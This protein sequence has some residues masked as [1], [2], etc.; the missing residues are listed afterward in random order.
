MLGLLV[1]MPMLAEIKEYVQEKDGNIIKYKYDTETHKAWLYDGTGVTATKLDFILQE[2]SDEENVTYQVTRIGEKAFT[3]LANNK[4]SGNINL[5]YVIIPEG[6]DKIEAN[7]FNNCS[8]IRLLELP[9]TMTTVAKNAFIGCSNMAYVCCKNTNANSAIPMGLPNNE[10]MTLFVPKDCAK[11]GEKGY[12]NPEYK[13]VEGNRFKDRIYEGEM[14]VLYSKT[15]NMTYVCAS[16]PGA[17][18]KAILIEGKRASDVEVKSNVDCEDGESYNVVGIGKS[19]FYNFLDIHTLKIGEGVTTICNNAFQ[20]C[21]NLKKLELPST[22]NTIGA[23]AFAE[24]NNLR[25]VWCKVVDAT[26]IDATRFPKSG[27]MSLYVPNTDYR[28]KGNWS[29]QFGG[30]IYLGNMVTQWDGYG[31]EYVCS[32]VSHE[33]TL[34][35]GQNE[36]KI[37]IPSKVGEGLYNVT[38][39]DRGAFSGLTKLHKVIIPNSIT[40]IGS[41]AFYG[42]NNLTIVHSKSLYPLDIDDNVF[43][44][45]AKATLFIPTSAKYD[46]TQKPGWNFYD[47]QEC[48]EMCEFSDNG[49]DYIGWT[50]YDESKYAKLIKGTSSIPEI[51]TP[52]NSY[53][54]ISIGES[55]FSGIRNLESLTISEEIETIADNAFKNCYDLKSISLP[56][57]LKSIG[58]SAFQYC[59]ALKKVTLP[60]SI[61][62]IGDNAFNGCTNL[63]EVESNMSALVPVTSTTFPNDIILYIP[64]DRTEQEYKD[65]GWIYSNCFLG[66]KVECQKSNMTY[67]YGAS[68]PADRKEAILLICSQTSETV[69]IPATVPETDKKV[70]SIAKNAF[71]NNNTMK[72]LIIPEGVESIGA[73]AFKNCSKLTT[74]VLPST[75]SSIRNYAFAQ[76]SNITKITSRIEGTKL[77]ALEENVFPSIV[78]TIYIPGGSKEYYTSKEGWKQYENSYKVGEATPN[79]YPDGIDYMAYDCYSDDHT[80][81]LTKIKSSGELIAVD[82]P[83]TIS[84]NGTTYTVTAIGESIFE[85]TS[86]NKSKIQTLVIGANVKT[87]GASAF[88]DWKGLH[89][90]SLPDG[91]VQI[92]QSAFLGDNN[93]DFKQLTIPNSV[94]TIAAYAFQG[95]TNLQNVKLPENLKSIE[96]HAFA[97]ITALETIDIPNSVDSIGAFA[98]QGCFKLN[99]KL[100]KNLKSIGDNSF[101]NISGTIS[102][103]IPEGVERIGAYAFRNCSKLNELVLPSSLLRIDPYAF[104]D[105]ANITNVISKIKEG[106]LFEIDKDV[107]PEAVR[108]AATLFVPIDEVTEG[109]GEN[110]SE[111][112]TIAKYQAT[113]GWK[114]FLL[115]NMIEGEKLQY[116][117]ESTKMVYE[118][119]TGPHKATLIGT[120]ADSGDV[121]IKS[122]FTIPTEDKPYQVIEIGESA[123]SVEKYPNTKNIITITISDGINK[124]GANAFNGCTGL[125]SINIPGTMKTIGANAFQGCTSLVKVNMDVPSVLETIESGAFMGCSVL[126]NLDLPSTLKTIGPSAFQSSGL[127]KISLRS[128]LNAIGDKAFYG[129]S[130][131]SDVGIERSTPLEISEDVF[132]LSSNNTA[133]L[134][135]PKESKS[136]YDIVG[137]NKFSNVVEGEFVD[138]CTDADLKVNFSCYRVKKD[139][140]KTELGAI[141]T[142]SIANVTDMLL[143]KELSVKVEG[144]EQQVSYTLTHI[145]KYAFNNCT[146]LKTVELPSSL[147]S[148]GD[149]AFANCSLIRE[150]VSNIKQDDLFTISDDVFHAD[151]KSQAKLYVPIGSKGTYEGKDYWS[152]FTHDNIENGK[153]EQTKTPDEYYLKYRYHTGKKKASVIEIIFPE[154]KEELTIPSSFTIGSGEDAVTYD[155]NSISPSVFNNK[156]KVRKL[157]IEDTRSEEGFEGISSIGA[158]AFQGC[159][160][161]QKIWLPKSVKSIGSKAFYGCNN[162]IRIC[163]ESMPTIENTDAFTAYSSALLFVP[164][165]TMAT[166]GA[167]WRDFSR[168]YEG[169]YEDESPDG[170]SRA[171][172]YLKQTGDKYTAILT[173]SKTPEPI[174]SPV[175]NINNNKSYDVTI[176]GKSAFTGK[177]LDLSEWTSLPESV[178]AIENDAFKNCKLKELA[179]PSSLKTIGNGAFSANNQLVKITLPANLNT[180]G[181]NAFKGCS[182]LEKIELPKNI[183]TLGAGV[184]EDCS[185]MTEV[186]SKIET[187]TVIK[188][189]AQSVPNAILYVP[190]GA[191]N[192]YSGW[193]FLYTLEGDSKLAR[194]VD[195]LDYAY[196]ASENS[197]NKAILIG[198][199]KISEDGAVTIPESVTI[200]NVEYHVV[201]VGKDVLYGNLNLKKLDIKASLASIGEN[202]FSGCSNLSEIICDKYYKQLDAL[203]QFDVLLYVLNETI[204]KSY[205]DAGWNSNHV[206]VGVRVEKEFDDG[207]KYAYTEGGS[208]A[209]LIGVWD[210][211]KAIDKNGAVIIPDY[212]EFKVDDNDNTKF[213]VISIANSVFKDNTDVRMVTIGENIASI[214]EN[215]FEGCTNLKEIVS[216]ISDTDVI[217]KILFSKPDAILFITD[218]NLFDTYKAKWDVSYILAGARKA[219]NENGLYYTCAT[220]DKVAILL[221]G[222]ASEMN[223]D[224][225]ILGSIEFKVND[226]DEEN[227]TFKVIAIA[228]N[229]FKGNT[230]MNT[231]TIGNNIKTIGA[232]A[233][234]GCIGLNKIWFPESLDS[235]AEKAFN[236]CYDIS[237]ICTKRATPQESISTNVFS[238]VSS[239]LYVPYGSIGAYSAN[240]V[241]GSFSKIKEGV[242]VDAIN[243]DGV[244]YECVINDKDE[245]VAQIVK[246]AASLTDVIIPSEVKLDQTPYRVAGIEDKAFEACTKLTVITSKISKDNLFDFNEN[247]FPESIYKSAV[248]YVPNDDETEAKY[249]TT[250]G[251]KKFEHWARGEKKTRTVGEMTYD[252]LVGVGTA[253]LTKTTLNTEKVRVD[254]TVKI[255]DVTYTVT[256]IGA[257]AFKTCNK[258][259]MVWLP[260]TLK[261]IDKLAFAGCYSIGYVSC[262]MTK[263]CDIDANTFPST[264]AALFV[265]NGYKSNYDGWKDKFAYMAEGELVDVCTDTKFSYDCVKSDGKNKAILRKYLAYDNEVEI[266]GTVNLSNVAYTVATIAKSSFENKNSITSLV[267]PAGVEEIDEGVFSGCSKLIWI[268]SKIEA[269][270]DIR[271]KNVFNNSKATLFIPSSAKVDAYTSKGWNFLNIFLGEKK[272]TTVDGWTYTYSTGDKKA[273]LTKVG[274]V[275]KDVTINGM[276]TI[277]K[278]EYTVTSVGEAV[279][280]GKT[281]IEALTIAK[282][283]ENIGANAF[284]GCNNLTFI[285]CEGTTPPTLGANAFP[286]YSV[287]VNVPNDAVGT[288]KNHPDWKPFGEHILGITTSVEDDPTG[289][290][291]ILPSTDSATPEVELWNGSDAEGDVVLTEIVTIGGSDFTL[292]AIAANAYDGNTAIT[293]I[294]IPSTVSSIGASAFAGCTNLKSITVNRVTPI[295]LST[296]AGVRGALTRAGG[297]SV[298]E[299]VNKETCIL[300]VPAESIDAYKQATGWKDFKKIY[301]IGTTA[302]NGIVISEGKPFDVYNL[303]GRKVKANTTSFSGLPS[304]V[305]IVKGKKVMVK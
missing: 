119:L 90:L 76:C 102:L 212:I 12:L 238:K 75:L 197:G 156:N 255:D 275:G 259:K 89:S 62:T 41:N 130:S 264:T 161:L 263:P 277:G 27:M 164:T 48:E 116:K 271:N 150:V 136:A 147:T 93:A 273:I 256:A 145:G 201:A 250:D 81:T 131:L 163:I 4:Y 262:D 260:S 53:N 177:V 40:T 173:N 175:T 118:Y 127:Q 30:R 168:K 66:H 172:I 88:K 189:N 247:V 125:I 54:V 101:E 269:P 254:G 20:K 203:S 68:D 210:K 146:N 71:L 154:D 44:S 103:S 249:K 110:E 34:Y 70:I 283:I 276:F 98:F 268:Q 52:V 170:V 282:S 286:S 32:T 112:K 85:G 187:E 200:E 229:A 208:E 218:A 207:L 192:R 50:K 129:C 22:L 191:A 194:D 206:Y 162:L 184:F 232:S 202:A 302:I 31:N 63:V 246:A 9:S 142:K 258:L 14:K 298:F 120:Y 158:N 6:I 2:F 91:L 205:V 217:S 122:S 227:T 79:V 270:I 234:Q 80:A 7:A 43:S 60:S 113:A 132:S 148:I 107:F 117:D 29:A 51:G 86:E 126:R 61:T 23:G 228:E 21:A 138:A 272:E 155:V 297:S 140:N 199:T 166:L 114:E 24:C 301:A 185:G 15:E 178:V 236:G 94:T 17:D 281:N 240:S 226:N 237:Y 252:Y 25:H 135:V 47:V 123:F 289:A 195:G 134:F 169:Y 28:S 82:V 8:N 293:S 69:D 292:T 176:I 105:C 57:T 133:T 241:W 13:W 1:S 304:G 109:E 99:I 171:Y 214:G 295:D 141:I 19:A 38:G 181:D 224:V 300:Y 167:G 242:F 290:Y 111:S 95:C 18:H 174:Q 294:V 33:A 37:E 64:S 303:Q 215:A 104:A 58:K 26:L 46:Y 11:T 186:I 108:N 96:N 73:Y 211:D 196:T 39:V 296:V 278:D 160:N 305:Y 143:K 153:W 45:K 67:V 121:T 193:D 265:P 222:K 220:G 266:P 221:E 10:L 179:L 257:N 287:T 115:Q 288:Y 251:W 139:E 284:D 144:S 35:I 180:L 233:F 36:T 223:K 299:G 16:G 274:N 128:G 244:T 92:G 59:I 152:S 188:S 74:I 209:I 3:T 245:N 149:K 190:D 78:P 235:I 77:F 204:K 5:D 97:N 84:V 239:T 280:K 65:C 291:N 230:D 183:T 253:T 243:Q 219:W 267:I 225:D 182:S 87:I 42:C 56:S 216:K 261:E 285:T 100:P 137:W 49:I 83:A 279:F 151:V 248:V 55:A 231:L 165:E 198:V 159:A 106:D 213:N 157:T 72:N 124:I